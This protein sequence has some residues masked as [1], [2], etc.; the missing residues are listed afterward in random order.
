MATPDEP[1]GPSP[2]TICAVLIQRLRQA[3]R[4]LDWATTCTERALTDAINRGPPGNP[5]IRELNKIDDLMIQADYAVTRAVN[6]AVT[7]FRARE[8]AMREAEEKRKAEKRASKKRLVNKFINIY[9][10]STFL[11]SSAS[12]MAFPP[13]CRRLR[14]C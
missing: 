3:Q 5:I 11:F 4:R 6:R 12:R 9:L 7:F 1:L 14:P 10:F 2:R 13:F 8:D